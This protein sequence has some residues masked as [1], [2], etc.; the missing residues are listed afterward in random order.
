MSV[1]FGDLMDHMNKI[2]ET[3]D[4]CREIIEVYKDADFVLGNDRLNRIVRVLTILSAITLPFIVVTSFYGMNIH[5]P[6]GITQGDY[7]PFI[8]LLIIVLAMS[9]GMLFFFHHKGWI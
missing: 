5:L 2:C 7:K 6:G 1:Y 9:G 3:L 4:E 8:F